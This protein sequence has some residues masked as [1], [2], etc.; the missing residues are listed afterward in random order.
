MTP[1]RR[2]VVF[3]LLLGAVSATACIPASRANARVKAATDSAWAARAAL[4]ARDSVFMPL[5]LATP[6]SFLVTFE[7]TKGTAGII[8]PGAVCRLMYAMKALSATKNAPAPRAPSPASRAI[9]GGIR[10]SVKRGRRRKL[11]APLHAR[12]WD[13]S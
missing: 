4:A 10:S 3:I 6:D 9:F 8:P 7:T 5:D 2:I 12:N 13:A 11:S 1:A